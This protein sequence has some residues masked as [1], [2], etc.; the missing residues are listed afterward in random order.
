MS[1]RCSVAA[2]VLSASSVE[3]SRIAQEQTEAA[4]R[5]SLK[6]LRKPIY[7]DDRRSGREL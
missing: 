4:I 6:L 1:M 5:A 7:P 2:I 3:L